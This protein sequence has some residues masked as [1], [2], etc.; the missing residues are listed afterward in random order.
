MGGLVFSS[1][2]HH[3]VMHEFL[4][5]GPYGYQPSLLDGLPWLKKVY[6]PILTTHVYLLKYFD[7]FIAYLIAV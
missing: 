4:I 5:Q 3:A 2:I 1:S 6:L 7:P